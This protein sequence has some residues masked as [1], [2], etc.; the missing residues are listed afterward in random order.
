[1]EPNALM[2]DLQFKGALQ[3]ERLRVG[4]TVLVP[5]TPGSTEIRGIGRSSA[6]AGPG[7][8]R[9]RGEASR[10]LLRAGDAG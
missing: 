6:P 4:G 2:V 1:M 7:P 10:L 3:I 5:F 9:R 8:M